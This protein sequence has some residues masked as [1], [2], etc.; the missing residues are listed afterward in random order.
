MRRLFKLFDDYF[1]ILFFIVIYY[2]N[3]RRKKQVGDTCRNRA[4]LHALFIKYATVSFIEDDQHVFIYVVFD[5][6]TDPVPRLTRLMRLRIIMRTKRSRDFLHPRA[7]R[8]ARCAVFRKSVKIDAPTIIILAR[9][10]SGEIHVNF[11]K[12]SERIFRTM[13]PAARKSGRRSQ[14]IR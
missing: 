12:I 3:T 14:I 6:T 8:C 13:V 9:S 7:S 1:N 5:K 11:T 10:A 2:H 4:Q